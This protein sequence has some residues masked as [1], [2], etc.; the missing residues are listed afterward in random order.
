MKGAP[1]MLVARAYK[2]CCSSR[3]RVTGRVHSRMNRHSLGDSLLQSSAVG[4]CQ[5]QQAPQ[6]LSLLR[7]F[8]SC[9]LLVMRLLHGRSLV[10]L[11]RR[12]LQ[13]TCQG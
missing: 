12:H 1:C 7:F 11:W 6:L 9:S 5:A 3:I 2:K 8:T 13:W 10:L 4:S